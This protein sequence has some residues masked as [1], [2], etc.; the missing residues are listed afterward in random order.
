[1]FLISISLRTSKMILKPKFCIFSLQLFTRVL[2]SLKYYSLLSTFHCFLFLFMSLRGRFSV[3][4]EC[5]R[6]DDKKR[7]AAKIIKYERS[8]KSLTYAVREY[9]LMKS[10]DWPLIEG[11]VQLHEAYLV[12]DYL[13][14]IMDL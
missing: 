2:I 7:W 9:D 12:R 8:S 6:K 1:M 5:T 3:V 13:I 11:V 14:L 10:S 4:Q